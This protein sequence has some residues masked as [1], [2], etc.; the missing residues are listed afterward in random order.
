MIIVLKAHIYASETTPAPAAH[1]NRKTKDGVYI[2]NAALQ[3]ITNQGANSYA[4]SITWGAGSSPMRLSVAE[5]GQVYITDWS[6]SHPGV[7]VMNPAAPTSTFKPVFS[8]LT[9]ATTGLSSMGGINVHGSI[10]H[11]WVTG[12]GVDT[13]LFTFDED[14]IDATTTSPGNLLQYNI[15]LLETPWQAAPTKVVYND[16]LNGNLQQNMNSCIAPDGRGGW[17][18]S[19]YRGE[20]AVLIPSLIHVGTDG[21][22]DFNSG[23]TPTLIGNSYTGG[24]AVNPA[25]T[26]LAMGCQDEV[27]VFSIVYSETGV[28]TLTRLHSIKPAMGS[29]TAGISYDRAGNLYVISNTSESLGVWAM[30]KA[31]NQF[32]TLAPSS[33]KLILT[34][35]GVEKTQNSLENISTYPNPVVNQ[36]NIDAGSA[37][38]DQVS[39]FSL[40]GELIRVENSNTSKLELS[41]SDL[42]SGVYI[43]KIKTN[44]GTAVRR[45]MKK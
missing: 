23:K 32:T 12:T 29:N 14:Y 45:I 2:L 35:T 7:W 25:G 20:D 33:S 13:K 27:K 6:D 41:V 18:I 30:P 17:W 1:P 22:V 3:D 43:L 15:G 40:K 26:V 38:I 16:G 11:C 19:Q 28:P 44:E 39:I 34:Y 8:G 42:I 21:M 31:D 24:M 9:K 37:N 36:L 4:G 10:A 5:D